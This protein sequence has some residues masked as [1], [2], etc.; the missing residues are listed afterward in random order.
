MAEPQTRPECIT[1]MQRET[2]VRHRATSSLR[3]LTSQAAP[4]AFSLKDFRCLR[5]R[6]TE[7]P[8]PVPDERELLGLK[9]AMNDVLGVGGGESGGNLS[10]QTERIGDGKLSTDALHASTERLTVEILHH[11]VGGAVG[12]LTELRDLHDARMV[13]NVDGTR[14][15]EEAGLD[16]NLP[17]DFPSHDV[18]HEANW[19]Q[20]KSDR[21]AAVR[22]KSHVSELTTVPSDAESMRT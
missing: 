17:D 16:G 6:S 12:L 13:H 21:S 8:Q 22:P 10:C 11:D 19:E 2:G 18:R 15:V 3:F 7:V 14:F 5:T 9:V 20:P 1:G 4:S